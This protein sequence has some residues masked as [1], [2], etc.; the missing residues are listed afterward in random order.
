MALFQT[1]L[2]RYTTKLERTV[3]GRY[4]TL[5]VTEIWGLFFFFGV[6][7]TG[8]HHVPLAVLKLTL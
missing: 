3:C 8:F 2:L 1:E 4:I 6:F 7:E 5:Y